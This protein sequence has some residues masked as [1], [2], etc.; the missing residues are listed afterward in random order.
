LP[1]Y[2]VEAWAGS[3]ALK[4]IER[5][6]QPAEQKI[7]GPYNIG[8]PIVQGNSSLNGS[9]GGWL[10]APYG[11]GSQSWHA[12]VPESWRLAE[13]NFF[14]TLDRSPIAILD[15]RTLQPYNPKQPYWLGRTVA[16]ELPGF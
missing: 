2:G 5:L 9:H 8:I 11:G 14:R 13:I 10:V 4:A 6:N 16:H 15:A 1:K 12:G 3:L 7:L